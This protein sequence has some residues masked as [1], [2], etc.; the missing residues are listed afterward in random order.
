[1][2]RGPKYN[3]EKMDKIVT[4]WET[5]APTA[6]FGGMTLAEL[7]ADIAPCKDTRKELAVIEDQ[8]TAKIDNRD[9][10][11]TFALGKC[12][13]VVNGVVGD[14]DFGPNSPL[15]EAM[16]YVRK[17]ERKSGLTRKT[18]VPSTNE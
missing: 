17:S 2:G 4:A 5:L 3:E 12:D 13:L 9:D 10:A 6:T 14:P 8:R 16:G 15:Y 11:D 1:M 18:K 7:K